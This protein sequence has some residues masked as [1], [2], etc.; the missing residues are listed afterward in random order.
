MSPSLRSSFGYDGATLRV[1]EEDSVVRRAGRQVLQRGVE[2]RTPVPTDSFHVSHVYPGTPISD[3][4]ERK[5]RRGVVDPRQVARGG[6][7]A[8]VERRDVPIDRMLTD[9]SRRC[10]RWASRCPARSAP[11]RPPD[12][13]AARTLMR[14][15]GRPSSAMPGQLRT[16][17]RADLRMC[18]RSHNGAAAVGGTRKLLAQTSQRVS[19]SRGAVRRRGREWTTKGSRSLHRR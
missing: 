10:L 14:R 15:R 9:S 1:A 6:C 5:E 13:R 7:A 4:P 12:A 2:G 16:R 3:K 11:W 8:R 17:T 19:D 18:Q